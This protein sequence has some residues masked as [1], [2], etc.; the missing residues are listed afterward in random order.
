VTIKTERHY[1]LGLAFYLDRENPHEA[2]IASMPFLQEEKKVMTIKRKNKNI[3]FRNNATL[4]YQR[5]VIYQEY[6]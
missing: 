6:G 1:I 4:Q 3:N 2:N 5:Y